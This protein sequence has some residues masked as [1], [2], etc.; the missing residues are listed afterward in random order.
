MTAEP[1]T[2]LA[3]DAGTTNQAMLNLCLKAVIRLQ[4]V[5]DLH[6]LGDDLRTNAI[7]L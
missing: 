1:P 5:N 3:I 2:V 7:S 4:T 6:R